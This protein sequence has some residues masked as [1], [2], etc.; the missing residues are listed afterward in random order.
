[1]GA[2]LYRLLLRPATFAW[3]PLAALAS[4]TVVGLM[5]IFLR[6]VVDSSVRSGIGA[7]LSWTLAALIGL[8]VGQASRSCSTRSDVGQLGHT[9]S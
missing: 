7:A 1:M 5:V 2:A 8:L 4:L 6:L 3:V 9:S